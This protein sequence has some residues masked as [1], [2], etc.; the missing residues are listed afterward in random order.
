MAEQ[1]NDS[2]T[3]GIAQ[4]MDDA[5][6]TLD[7]ALLQ[8]GLSVAII[9]RNLPQF[10]ALD[11]VVREME[12][13]MARA[14]RQ[15]DTSWDSA[16][17][18]TPLRSVPLTATE[19]PES[20][21]STQ[22]SLDSHAEESNGTAADDSEPAPAQEPGLSTTRCLWLTVASKIGSL[23]LKAVDWSVNENPSVLDVALL[24]YDGRQATLKLWVNDSAD[25]E[26]VREALVSSLRNHLGDAEQT[27]LSINFEPGSAA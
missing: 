25:P 7:T 14:R 21:E 9:R 8:A 12:A 2:S 22:N 19:T 13:A 6:A 18:K 16:E 5:L 11:R 17:E 26:G 20:P 23:D 27:D 4:E 24:D 10:A 3:T 1:A 15:L